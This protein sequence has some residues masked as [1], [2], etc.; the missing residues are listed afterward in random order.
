M[1]WIL[2]KLGWGAPNGLGVCPTVMAP[3]LTQASESPDLSDATR[4]SLPPK[5]V[6]NIGSSPYDH[7]KTLKEA[8]R[9][10]SE[11]LLTADSEYL[12]N[13]DCIRSVGLAPP[14][15]GRAEGRPEPGS[16]PSQ[17]NMEEFPPVSLPRN[18]G[19]EVSSS[20]ESTS[21]S[22]NMGL[23]SCL[24]NLDLASDPEKGS[25]REATL[26]PA[27][28]ETMITNQNEILAMI[29][30]EKFDDIIDTLQNLAS[31]PELLDAAERDLNANP[32]SQNSV[33]MNDQQMV[34]INNLLEKQQQLERRRDFLARRLNRNTARGLGA[35]VSNQISI[36]SRR[37]R[38]VVE[39]EKQVSKQQANLR[40]QT[41]M[42]SFPQESM[43]SMSTS[44][45]ISL[46]KRV[47]ANNN[48]KEIREPDDNDL[49]ANISLPSN[50]CSEIKSVVS[51]W[52]A[53]SVNHLNHDSDATESSSGGESCDEDENYNKNN[54]DCNQCK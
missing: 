49:N 32:V 19:S 40:S 35:T 27:G 37:V 52:K 30:Q 13:S 29:G 17:L 46:V 36:L 16:S 38:S 22:N 26:Q 7:I 31:N 8:Q 28:T 4:H 50:F 21:A 11:S 43:K 2:N 45:L 20:V 41:R 10:P 18:T 44:D 25:E 54:V 39:K 3:A 12:L 23:Q 42:E 15:C 6:T 34:L 48:R 24:R 33:D 53:A 5:A 14:A 47:E 1:L 51:E 9:I